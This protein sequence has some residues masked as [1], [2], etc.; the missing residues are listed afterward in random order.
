M[1]GKLVERLNDTKT[2]VSTDGTTH[3]LSKMA[4]EHL[5][6]TAHYLLEF[7]YSLA[8]E[9]KTTKSP[10]DFIEGTPLFRAIVAELLRRGEKRIPYA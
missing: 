1:I 4:I 6:N 9:A 7:R 10:T 5:R 2:W 8:A 3:E